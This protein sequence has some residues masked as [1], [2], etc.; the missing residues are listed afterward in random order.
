MSMMDDMLDH[1]W[2]PPVLTCRPGDPSAA[3][4]RV[5]GEETAGSPSGP[6]TT[7]PTA[8]PAAWRDS[9]GHGP[10]EVTANRMSMGIDGYPRSTPVHATNDAQ[11]TLDPPR[12]GAS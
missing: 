11:E 8:R 5:E 4:G 3:I 2:S 12:S 10:E 9:R 1:G 7:R 6:P